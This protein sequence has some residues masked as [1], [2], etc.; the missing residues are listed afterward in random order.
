MQL[1]A[2]DVGCLIGPKKRGKRG[3]KR[4]KSNAR[5]KVAS[6]LRKHEMARRS[7]RSLLDRR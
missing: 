3:C 7:T 1:L 5:A 4:R 6:E 2:L